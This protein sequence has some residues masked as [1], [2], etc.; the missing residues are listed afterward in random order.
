[1]TGRKLRVL[2]VI[3]ARVQPVRRTVAGLTTRREE[4]RLRCMSRVCRVVVVGLMAANARCRK[5]GVIVV[6]VAV[7]ALAWGNG[8][9]TGQG[10]RRVVVVKGRVRP[11]RGVMT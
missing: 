9:R 1:M 11:Y 8:V 2:S 6:D 7:G 10:E 3:E 4:L 5:R